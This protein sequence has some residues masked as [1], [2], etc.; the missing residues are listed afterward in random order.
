MRTRIPWRFKRQGFSTRVQFAGNFPE[1][2]AG[3]AGWGSAILTA[4]WFP[5]AAMIRIREGRSRSM[6]AKT[7]YCSYMFRIVSSFSCP[8]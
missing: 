8:G 7:S 3:I 6:P 4:S 2:S 1:N 5:G